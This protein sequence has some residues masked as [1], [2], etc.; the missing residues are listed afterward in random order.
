MN[1]IKLN[2][3]TEL[4]GTLAL[5]GIINKQVFPLL[6]QAVRAIAQQTA[7]DWQENIYGAK[8]WSGEKDAYAKT[9]SWR[10]VN[11]FSAMVSSG[12]RYDQEIENGRPARDL[13]RMLDTSTKV[14]R[15]KDGRRFLVIPFRHNMQKLM[16][17]GIYHMAKSLEA[18]TITGQGLRA[19]GEVTDLSPK[20]G[21][22]AAAKQTPFLSSLKTKQA[23]MVNRNHY[24]WG[25]ALQRGINMRAGVKPGT[26]RWAQGM[27][28]FDTSTPG[29][30]KSSAYLTFRVMME[31]SDGWMV[32]AQPGQHLA[33]KT[34]EA[35]QPKAQ[36]AFAEAIRRTLES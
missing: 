31:G 32:P 35:M 10:M 8:L 11:D 28:R 29:G 7:A 26:P 34:T 9:I 23:A 30:G 16:A 6:N 21:M 15:T 4:S 13:K 22:S 27:Y 33:K 24:A 3:G 2:L 19:S 1:E 36:L 14:R 20:G 25:Q 17:A 12:Y 18:T 5:Q